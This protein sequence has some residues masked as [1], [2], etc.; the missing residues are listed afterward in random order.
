MILTRITSRDKENLKRGEGDLLKRILI[1]EERL[2]KDRLIDDKENSE[3][4]RGAA[5]FCRALNKI[6]E[7]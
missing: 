5:Y 3:F 1:E 6:M 2:L 4:Y 7:G